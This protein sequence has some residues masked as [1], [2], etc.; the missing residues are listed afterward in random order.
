MGGLEG[1]GGLDR[2]LLTVF[3]IQGS[4][5]RLL[6]FCLVSFIIEMTG[7]CVFSLR[8]TGLTRGPFAFY[9]IHLPVVLGERVKLGQHQLIRFTR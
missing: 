1:V 4:W 7:Y 5:Q 8:A 3:A 9:A 2:R 6:T